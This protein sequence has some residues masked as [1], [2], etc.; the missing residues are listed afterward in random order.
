MKD[1]LKSQVYR[2]KLAVFKQS[3]QVGRNSCV[4]LLIVGAPG[5]SRRSARDGANLSR[6]FVICTVSRDS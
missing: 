4:W 2:R 5:P 1:W 3:T 6:P